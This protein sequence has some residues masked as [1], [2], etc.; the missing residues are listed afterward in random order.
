MAKK[1]KNIETN[2]IDTSNNKEV[3]NENSARDISMN[4]DNIL[5]NFNIGLLEHDSAVLYHIENN[6]KPF[7]VQNSKLVKVPVLIGN[8]EIWASV[9]YDGY[10]RDKEGKIMAP[11]IIFNRVD[12]GKRRDYMNKVDPTF[13]RTNFTAYS[14]YSK[15][16]YYDKF[17]VLTGQVPQKE[18]HIVQ[19]PD[20]LSLTYDVVIETNYQSQMN[21]L[22]EAFL[23][24]EN[25]YWGDEK[26]KFKAKIE[27]ISD[28]SQF[29]ID[30]ERLIKSQFSIQLDGYIIPKV[31]QKDLNM[32]GKNYSTVKVRIDSE[33]VNKL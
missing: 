13:P 8:P 22:L 26:Y 31:I 33:V 2:F 12:I 20:Y 1:L 11:L 5:D 27:N 24:A 18:L 4:N 6:I 21:H 7:I 25:S 19:I 30:E 15:R 17:S 28:T 29:S 9:Q 23:Y 14:K 16:N 10:Y 32:I 3:I